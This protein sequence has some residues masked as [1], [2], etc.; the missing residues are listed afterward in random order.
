MTDSNQKPIRPQHLPACLIVMDGLAYGACAEA[1]ECG[2]AVLAARTPRLDQ[3]FAT[4]PHTR[5]LAAG[6]AVGLP[7]GQMGNS[8]VGHL[9]I[10]A[11]RIVFQELTRI[12]MAIEDGSFFENDVLITA[13]DHAVQND[14]TVHLMGLVSDGGVHS[15][16]N[17]IYAL[18]DLCKQRGAR[19][20]A[21]HCFLDGRDTPPRSGIT[22]LAQLEA[23]CQRIQLGHI[24]SVM[25]RYWAMDR[26]QRWDRIEKAYRVLV[27]GGSVDSSVDMIIQQ[28]YDMNITDEFIEPVAITDSRFSDGDAVVFF[29]F[30]PDRAREITRALVDDEFA[31]FERD[32][33]PNVHFVCLTQYDS[34]IDA[35]VAFKKELLSSVLADVLAEQGLTQLHI[36]ETEKYAHVTFFFNGG[37]ETPKAGEQ[38]ILVPSPKVATYDL[39]PEMSAVAVGDALV[40][41]IN[42]D[43]ADVYICNFANGDM[44]GHT[45]VFE[46]AVK[47]VETVDAQVGRVVDAIT[48]RGGSVY[49]TADHGNAEQMLDHDGTTP[50]TAHTCQD[51]PFIVI[52]A[53]VEKLREGALCDIAPT[54][55]KRLGI[56]PPEQW[57]GTDLVVY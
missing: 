22:Y 3:L 13:V 25:G 35:P 46:A 2:N 4:W 11:G 8:E 9:N 56:T 55:L 5:L 36:A 38:R 33:Q 21:V 51:V 27:E 37:I 45:G 19:D 40:D 12:D 31:G 43:A 16:I 7:E 53:D 28:N 50:F 41:A 48:S 57:T 10:G 47:A 29:N 52:N 15:S 20:V 18:L 42:S 30:R 34:T 6:R 44:V 49:I 54:M 17:H 32:I 1:A 24:G 39:L 26:D 14:K 23:Y